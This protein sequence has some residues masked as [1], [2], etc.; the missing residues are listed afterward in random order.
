MGTAHNLDALQAESE[1]K[2]KK[3]EEEKTT[4]GTDLDKCMDISLRLHENCVDVTLQDVS[5]STC[6]ETC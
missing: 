3:K 4:A 1:S 5:H 2:E 6:L